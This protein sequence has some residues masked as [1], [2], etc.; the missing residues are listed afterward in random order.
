[1]SECSGPI[2]RYGHW[3]HLYPSC[4]GRSD[5]FLTAVMFL[6]VKETSCLS[7]FSE[8]GKRGEPPTLAPPKKERETQ[9]Q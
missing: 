7:W 1:M 3:N 2:L 5:V 8:R 4:M 6:I 9:N